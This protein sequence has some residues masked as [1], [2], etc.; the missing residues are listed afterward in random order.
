MSDRI[1]GIFGLAFAALLVWAT[2]RIEESFIQDP[3]GPKAFPLVI[4]ALVVLSAVVMLIKPDQN[5]AWP[6]LKKWLELVL[7]VGILV[8]YAVA[9]PELGF[10]VSSTFLAIFLVWRLGGSLLQA[11]VGGVVMSGGIFLVFGYGLHLSLARG[12]WGF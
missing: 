6:G 12:P 10:F 1:F 3:L 9:L 8:I 11:L 4:A 5:P 2:G 7:T